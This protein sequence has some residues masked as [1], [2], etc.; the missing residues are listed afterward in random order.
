MLF[1]DVLTALQFIIDYTRS[2]I[3][4]WLCIKTSNVHL[5]IDPDIGILRVHDYN[6][7]T[8]MQVVN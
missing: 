4:M 5:Y 7:I 8:A 6:Y 2:K 1:V 3:P